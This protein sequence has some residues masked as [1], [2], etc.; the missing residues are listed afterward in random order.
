VN[1]MTGKYTT[2]FVMVLA[3]A[4]VSPGQARAKLYV[5]TTTSDLASIAR[6]VGGE[7]VEVESLARGYQDPHFVDPKPSFIVKL[8]RADLYV[9]RGLDLEVGWAPVLETGA[10]NPHILM[11]APG[12]VDASAGIELLEVPTGLI[13]RSLGDIHPFG[14][15]HYQLDPTNART[16]AHNIFLGFVRVAP[17][18]RTY[19][20]GRLSAFNTSVEVKLAE[21]K[22][23]L[24]PY[25]GSKIVTYHKNWEYFARRFGLRTI[26]YMEPKPGIAPSPAHLASLITLMQAENCKLIIKAPY[27]PNNLTRLVAERTGARVLVLPE[28]PGGIDDTEDYFSFMDYCVRQVAE[29]LKAIP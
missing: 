4:L 5:V 12:Y 20:A 15:P 28:S 18:D 7:K 29:A 14:N 22:K 1:T 27:S 11:G 10:R 23:L 3:L 8:N 6:E 24:A 2:L 26:G 9:K 17:A 19:F 21:W 13:D 16:M 25:Q